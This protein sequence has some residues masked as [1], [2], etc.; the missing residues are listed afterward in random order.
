MSPWADS[1]SPTIDKPLGREKNT[2]NTSKEDENRIGQAKA[3]LN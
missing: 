1:R 3:M 2:V